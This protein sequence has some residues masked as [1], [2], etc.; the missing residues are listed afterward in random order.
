MKI[1]L[2][3]TLKSRRD[4]KIEKLL[5]LLL[6]SASS[7]AGEGRVRIAIFYIIG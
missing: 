4:E 6:S 5:S 3:P 7:E 2:I 1:I